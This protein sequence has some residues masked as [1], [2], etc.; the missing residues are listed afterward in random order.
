MKKLISICL[1]LMLGLFTLAGRGVAAGT[2]VSG[3]LDVL[4]FPPGVAEVYPGE[5]APGWPEDVPLPAD[6]ALAGSLTLKDDSLVAMFTVPQPL[7]EVAPPYLD[8]LQTRS[9]VLVGKEEGDEGE[10]YG[11]T[12][13]RE[14]TD[15]LSLVLYDNEGTETYGTLYYGAEIVSAVRTVMEF[16]GEML[17]SLADV[18]VLPEFT[19]ED[20]VVVDEAISPMSVFIDEETYQAKVEAE[21]DAAKLKASLDSQLAEAGWRPIDFGA[22]GPAVWGKY[23]L[24]REGSIWKAVLLVLAGE[25]EGT[26]FV[27]VHA[28]RIP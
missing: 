1:G 16:V 20:A 12:F 8:E 5:L 22:A 27:S 10:Y 15:L 14:E 24:E 21:A 28:Y 25:P 11:Y 26:F 13:Q 23:E 9:W 2:D 3:I 6:A 7:D 18:I 4:L 19:F 17:S